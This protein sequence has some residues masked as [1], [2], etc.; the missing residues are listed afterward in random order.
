[1][2]KEL[3]RY[4]TEIPPVIP[5]SPSLAGMTIPIDWKGIQDDLQVDR[6]IAPVDWILPGEEAAEAGLAAFIEN[7][8]DGYA[9]NLNDPGKRGQSGLSPWL[10]FRSAI[11]AAGGVGGSAGGCG[12]RL[13][14]GL[15]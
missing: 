5:R 8:L 13:K 15:P 14:S 11:C 4:L 3:S 7:G 12:S 1:M 6:D 9:A 2:E 10:H